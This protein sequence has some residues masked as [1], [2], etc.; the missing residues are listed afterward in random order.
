MVEPASHRSSSSHGQQSP[1]YDVVDTARRDGE[2]LSGVGNF[3]DAVS[4]VHGLATSDAAKAFEDVDEHEH[5]M[6][7]HD[8]EASTLRSISPLGNTTL[9]QSDPISQTKDRP[10]TWRSLPKKSQLFLLMLA[11]CAEP[12]TQTSLQSYMYYQLKSFDP[13]LSESTV[14]SQVGLMQGS[15]T[16]AQ[17]ITAFLWGKAADSSKIGRKRVLV[18][19]LLGTGVATL[20]FGFSRTFLTAM[21]FRSLG[22]ALNGNVGVMRTMISEIVEEKK[23]A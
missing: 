2:L 6:R 18:I 4:G 11:R 7:N 17:F 16:M 20:G 3:Q 14:A 21:I 1:K 15:F 23:F 22:G 12:L 5:L 8:T 19:G 10:V 9:E 13:D